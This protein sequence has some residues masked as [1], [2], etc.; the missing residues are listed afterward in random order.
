[1]APDPEG[2]K[3]T[4][5][6]IG[7]SLSPDW[8]GT[9]VVQVMRTLWLDGADADTRSRRIN[10]AVG[11]LAGIGPK[12]EIEAMLVAQMIAI[13]NASMECLRR[14][15]LEG[16]SFEGW[17]EN[18]TQA[19]KLSRT[20]VTLLEALNRHRGKSQQTVR[21]EHVHIH[22]GGQ[23]IVGNVQHGGGR[24][25]LKSEE[26]PHALGHADGAPLPS[27]IETKREAVPIAGREG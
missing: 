17:R 1:M 24:G 26:Q 2:P 11:G 13:H 6:S 3:T 16:Q 10:A 12:D 22:D 18:L 4:L 21:V 14:A 19:S 25:Q 5:S 27:D 23:A 9:L 20:H 15:A 8:N 7:G